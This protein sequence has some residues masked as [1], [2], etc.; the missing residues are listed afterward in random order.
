VAEAVELE[1]DRVLKEQARLRLLQPPTVQPAAH[2]TNDDAIEDWDAELEAEEVHQRAAVAGTPQ[3]R[4]EVCRTCPY[5]SFFSANLTR[6][7]SPPPPSLQCRCV[8]YMAELIR[9]WV[10]SGCGV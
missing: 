4:A 6:S 7:F 3:M 1:H 5:P 2:I 10:A 8:L 9:I